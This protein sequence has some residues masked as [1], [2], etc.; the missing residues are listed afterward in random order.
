MQILKPQHLNSAISLNHF[1]FNATDELLENS[2]AYQ[3]NIHGW[4]AQ[5]EAKK[6]AIFGL[7]MRQGG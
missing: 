3:P 1:K 2:T 6:A 4:V 7:N 5:A